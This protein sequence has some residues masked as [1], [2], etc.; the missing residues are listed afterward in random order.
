METKYCRICGYRLGFEPWGDDEK[1]PTYEIGK[2]MMIKK[3]ITV[4]KKDAEI[5]I[6]PESKNEIGLWIAHP[7][8]YVVSISDVRKM[9]TMINTALQYSNSGIPVNAETAKSVL[10]DMRIKS[11]NSLY[12]SYKIIS[13]SIAEDKIIITP[14]A[15]TNRGVF[16]DTKAKE[17]FDIDDCNHAIGLLLR[18]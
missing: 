10:K 1:T 6:F 11:W 18:L 14:F 9:E 16:P 15:Y 3:Q 2:T 8:C 5:I 7:P 13:Y 4:C 12:K 17:S